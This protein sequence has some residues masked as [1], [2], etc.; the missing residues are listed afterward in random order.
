MLG[1]HVATN[2]GDIL[3]SSAVVC[4]SVLF[5][6]SMYVKLHFCL[7]R[8]SVHGRFGFIVQNFKQLKLNSLG[9]TC[10]YFCMNCACM[11]VYI[12]DLIRKII[13]R[14]DLGRGIEM[15]SFTAK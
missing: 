9:L 11:C 7:H 12:T 6:V 5:C 14:I 2:S 13:Q 4:F 8:L 15:K 1:L 10:I 3:M